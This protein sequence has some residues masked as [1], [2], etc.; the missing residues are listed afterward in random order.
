[1]TELEFYELSSVLRSET[2][3]HAMNFFTI[4]SGYMI[5]VY[6]VGEKLSRAF[7]ILISILYTLF[8]I[9]PA[10]ALF[11]SLNI[12]YI[13]SVDFVDQYPNTEIVSVGTNPL[14]SLGISL[15]LSW[16]VS[17]LF[18]LQRRKVLSWQ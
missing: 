12:L 10:A 5:A 4:W 2:G 13:L 9:P 16:F 3:S 6:L 8:I 14:A 18:L 15:F 17:L 11:N 1:M 7:S